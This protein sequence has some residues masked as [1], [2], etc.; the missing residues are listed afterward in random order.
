MTAVSRMWLVNEDSGSRSSTAQAANNLLRC[1]G[2]E[3]GTA[4][5]LNV[6]LTKTV[7]LL[8]NDGRALLCKLKQLYIIWYFPNN[9]IF[10]IAWLNATFF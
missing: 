8:L 6:L 2:Y 5:L 9:Q 10:C 3:D 4:S 7:R 1:Y